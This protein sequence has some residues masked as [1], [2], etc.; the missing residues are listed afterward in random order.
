MVVRIRRGARPH[1]YIAEWRESRGLS[2]DRLADR[3]DVGRATMWKYEAGRLKVGPDIQAAIAEALNIDPGD[4]WRPPS[5]R[6]SL[7]R[8]AKDL[9]DESFAAI[10]DLVRRLSRTGT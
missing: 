2:T 7:D 5:D 10:A 1:L 8:M 4:L 3:L 6:P 9:P